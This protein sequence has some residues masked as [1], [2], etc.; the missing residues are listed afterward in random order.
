MLSVTTLWRRMGV[1]LVCL[2]PVLAAC[3]SGSSEPA[4]AP[5][6]VELQRDELVFNS[7]RTGNHEIFVMKNDGSAVRALTNDARFDNWWARPSPDRKRLLFYRAPKGKHESYADAALW[8]MNA[9]GGDAVLLRA[10]QTDGWTQQGHAEWSPDGQRLA[11]F[12]SAGATLQIFLTDARAQNAVKL[13]DRPGITT[14]VSW[15]PDGTRVLFNSCAATPCAAV[16]YEIFSMPAVAGAAATRLTSNTVAD[17]DPYYSPDG[18]RIAWLARVDPAAFPL[19]GGNLGAWA[20]RV[21]DLDGNNVRD[22]IND[23]Q[24]NSKPAWSLDGQTV[25]FHRMVPPD[26]RFRVFRINVDGTGLTELTRGAA[27]NSEYPSN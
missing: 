19:P 25:Y 22:L 26:Y 13:T 21:S 7:N 20:I 12:G 14:D 5:A 6:G 23:G 8:L 16:N 24:V 15:S 4:P 3:G 18:R 2:L 1:V 10:A 17:F 9:D 11:M 27:G